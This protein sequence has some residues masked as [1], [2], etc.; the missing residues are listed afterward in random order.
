MLVILTTHPIQYQIPI[1]KALASRGR[2][3]F[4]VFFM[5]DQ[6]VKIT[7]DPGF[8]RTFSWDIDLLN[9]FDY[10]FL[11][12]Q[13]GDRQ[14]S[15]RWLRMKRTF[16]AK[17]RKAG[18]TILW[19]QGWQVAAYWQAAGWA[20]L[21]GLELWL[22][23]ESNSRSASGERGR[24]LRRFSVTCLLRQMDRLLFIGDANRR[25]YLE[26]GISESDLS[27]APYCVD[28]NRFLA[29]SEL[30]RTCRTEI[31]LRWRIPENAFCFLFVGKFVVKKRPLDLALAAKQLMIEVPQRPIHIL[32]VGAGELGPSLRAV[33]SVAFDCD[34]GTSVRSDDPVDD[35]RP[36]ASFV[37]FLNQSEIS[38]AYVSADCLVLPSDGRE[39]WGLVV[40]EAMAS[41]LPC[42]ISDA[43]GC[44]E[45]LVLPHRMDLRYP[46]GDVD[47]LCGALR[48]VIAN[49]PSQVEVQAH[50]A[51]YD[52]L[53]TVE[54][55]ESLYLQRRAS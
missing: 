33:S 28:N 30:A 48:R 12:M 18:A 6:G 49:A 15:F 51:K 32:W 26:K 44:A 38:E 31:R 9:G 25:F 53:R 2:V 34:C 5:S 17:L 52:V 4:R 20:K 8:Q 11:D 41:G 22:R 36:P 50:I 47:A 35:S 55:V 13:V 14:D 16:G 3:P 29:S 10:E 1:W 7:Y 24:A 37:G 21:M 46:V 39:T 54:V 27:F 40:N 42:V 43:C 23:G 19:L 45:D